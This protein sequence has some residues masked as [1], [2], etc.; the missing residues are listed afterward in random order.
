MKRMM[1][2][3][4]IL[5]IAMIFTACTDAKPDTAAPASGSEA[6]VAK[7]PAPAPAEAAPKSD[8]KKA[9]DDGKQKPDSWVKLDKSVDFQEAIY[10]VNAIKKMKGSLISAADGK[11]FLLIDMS[12]KNNSKEEMAVSS[13]M[14]FD[15]TDSEG[16]KYDISIGGLVNLDEYKLESLDGGINAGEEMKGGLAYEVPDSA[17]GFKLTI[18][19]LLGNEETVIELDK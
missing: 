1:T 14:L 4:W 12:I 19:S 15:L 2:P 8:A 17:K 18:K 11:K 7:E 9:S 13:I 10:K 3:V 16:K 5:A 6:S